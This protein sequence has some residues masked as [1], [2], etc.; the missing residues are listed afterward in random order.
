MKK[1]EAL[2]NLKN[3]LEEVVNNNYE[4]DALYNEILDKADDLLETLDC[5]LS[6]HG[7]KNY[8]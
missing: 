7:G 3:A 8:A 5:Y 1:Q 6:R 4:D 2:E